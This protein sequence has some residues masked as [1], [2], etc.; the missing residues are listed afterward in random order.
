MMEIIFTII[1][2][3]IIGLFTYREKT[4]TESHERIIEKLLKQN[5]VEKHNLVSALKSYTAQDYN[6]SAVLPE[7]MNFE[8]DKNI[9]EDSP[10]QDL[11]DLSIENPELFDKTLGIK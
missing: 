10:F 3:S 4:Q 6:T 2:L 8:K 5:E 11:D 9:E 1:I 7:V